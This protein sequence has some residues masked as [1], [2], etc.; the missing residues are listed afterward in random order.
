M[1]SEKGFTLGEL[2]MVVVILGVM[3]GVAL[4][5]FYPQKEKGVIAEAVAVLGAIRQGEIAWSLE[6]GGGVNFIDPSSDWTVIGMADPNNGVGARFTYSVNAA[7]G[8]AIA[9]RISTSDYGGETLNLGLGDGRWKNALG[10]DDDFN[11]VVSRPHPYQP[12]N[13]N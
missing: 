9:A 12:K 1:I 4:P 7:A 2:L 6:N 8:L 5:K 10:D 11:S 13:A 3:G